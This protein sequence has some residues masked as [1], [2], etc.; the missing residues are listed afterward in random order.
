M[1]FESVS[2]LYRRREN[3]VIWNAQVSRDDLA[4]YI[5]ESRR[6]FNRIP[7]E[8]RNEELWRNVLRFL[9]QVYSELVCLPL[10]F[11]DIIGRYD[12]KIIDLE[13]EMSKYSEMFPGSIEGGLILLKRLSH[14]GESEDNPMMD[15]ARETGIFDNQI[16]FAVVIDIRREDSWKDLVKKSLRRN[17]YE[18]PQ[19]LTSPNEAELK[20]LDRLV[21]LGRAFDPSEIYYAPIAREIVHLGYQFMRSPWP[22]RPVN[23][24]DTNKNHWERG[25]LPEIQRWPVPDH[26]QASTQVLGQDEVDRISNH[27][28]PSI[29][30]A[31]LVGSSLLGNEERSGDDMFRSSSVEAMAVSLESGHF[32]FLEADEDHRE[33]VFRF[34]GK[35]HTYEKIPVSEIQKGDHIFI[36]KSGTGHLLTEVTW[37]QLGEESSARIKDSQERWKSKLE[38]WIGSQSGLNMT[39]RLEKASKL[40]E[41]QGVPK[42]SSNNLKNWINRRKILPK[43]EKGFRIIMNAIGLEEVAT[44]SWEEGVDLRSARQSAGTSLNKQ[45]IEKAKTIRPEQYGGPVLGP[46]SLK[47]EGKQTRSLSLYRVAD[48]HTEKF[49]LKLGEIGKLEEE[50]FWPG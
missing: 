29:A 33:L 15:C 8:H 35:I 13:A 18:D 41:G 25:G 40:L 20:K 36:N 19:V 4:E 5:Q 11:C 2:Q 30:N 1:S 6:F 45:L 43:D 50:I 44:K 3:L 31:T 12:S 7:Q 34:E 38:E 9:G 16:R 46:F 37:D 24:N 10:P 26:F 17:G 23:N 22:G 27:I 21:T 32:V 14:L 47:S 49:E 48:V 28:F 39:A 42:A